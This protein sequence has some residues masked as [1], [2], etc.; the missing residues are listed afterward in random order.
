ML[1]VFVSRSVPIVFD[2]GSECLL[3]FTKKKIAM[4]RRK[5]EEEGDRGV[6]GG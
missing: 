4:T 6:D 1:L 5:K 3:T 2:E